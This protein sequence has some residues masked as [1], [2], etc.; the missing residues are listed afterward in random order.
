MTYVLFIV[1]LDVAAAPIKELELTLEHQ[2]RGWLAK[3]VQF[4][5][6]PLRRIKDKLVVITGRNS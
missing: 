4:V 6:I 1:G 2:V 3:G 5:F